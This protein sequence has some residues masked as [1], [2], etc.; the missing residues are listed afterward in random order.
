MIID[1][2]THIFPPEMR[3]DRN[4]FC[5]RDEG[6]STLHKN[7]KAKMATAEDLIASMDDT[8]VERSVVCGFSWSDSDL[9]ALHNQYLLDSAA[10][11]PHRL[12][13]FLSLPLMN[14]ERSEAELEQGIRAGAKGIG[15]I[16]FYHREMTSRDLDA[17][18]PTLGLLG[19][20]KVPLLLHTNETLGHSYP[21]KGVTPLER[22]YEL[23]VSFPQMTLILA[24]WGGGLP[25]YELMPDVAKKMAR[26]YY[27][28]AASPFLYSLKIYNI[29]SQIVGPEKIL[30]GSD[31][32]L[33][34]PQRYLQELKASGLTPKDQ[35][36]ILGLNLSR[37]LG[38]GN[39]GNE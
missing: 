22:F 29:V 11:F 2:H 33:I 1:C 20:K 27:D 30:F 23:I 35:E 37:L 12:I 26:V 14:P 3:K 25:F 21:G 38:L 8:G 36:G 31:F 24:H 19:K 39:E 7:V 4:A 17:I 13:V 16:A 32:P 10:R 5:E 28:T 18:T 9:C 34:S 6:F 15:E